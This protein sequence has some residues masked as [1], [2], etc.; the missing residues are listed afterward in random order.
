MYFN[1]SSSAQSAWRSKATSSAAMVCEENAAELGQERPDCRHADRRQREARSA[2]AGQRQEM[3]C[4]AARLGGS[5]R[6]RERRPEKN[7]RS[8]SCGIRAGPALVRFDGRFDDLIARKLQPHVGGPSHN[9]PIVPPIG[10]VCD[11]S[12]CSA[13]AET[14]GSSA[15]TSSGTRIRSAH[16]PLF[17]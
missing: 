11:D 14:C 7:V 12:C 13:A 3:L 8:D 5:I 1:K 16:V 9:Q 17:K 2:R 4:R 15:N 10:H 6:R